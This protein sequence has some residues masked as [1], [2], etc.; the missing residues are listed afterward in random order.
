MNFLAWLE[1]T[2]FSVWLRE[3]DW[4][5]PI[6]LCFH[7]VGMGLVVGICI[8][9]CARVLGYSKNAPID[10]FDK[11]FDLAW[12]GFWMNAVSGVALFCGSPRRLL[13]TPAFLIKMVL[14]VAAGFSL[15]ILTRTLKGVMGPQRA[16]LGPDAGA[17]QDLSQHD[18]MPMGA[19]VAAVFPILCWIGAI[20]SGRLIAYTIG[21]PPV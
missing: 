3:S 20:V 5:H 15:W 16:H 21:P 11:L 17:G 14:I 7:A 2:D 8:M 1:E 6:V 18:A 13:E 4:G 19:K 9:F 10:G 12:I